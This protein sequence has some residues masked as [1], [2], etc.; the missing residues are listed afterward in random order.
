MHPTRNDMPE[1]QRKKVAELL[2]ANLALAIDLQ[3]QTKQA[4]WNVKGPNF[5]GLHKLFDE[6]AEEVAEFVDE[7]AERI[8]AL[9]GVAEGTSQVVVKRTSLPEYPLDIVHWKDHIEALSNSF[10]AF[11]KSVRAGIDRADEMRDKDTSDLFTSISR[12]ID[13]SLWFLEAHVQDRKET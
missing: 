9:A 12:E 7:I 8:T 1:S 3:L 4:H 2:N 5:I 6:L 11:G 13:K 10:A